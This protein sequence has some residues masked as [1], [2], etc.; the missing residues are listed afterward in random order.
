ML[1]HNELVS[2]DRSMNLPKTDDN[3][4][5]HKNDANTLSRHKANASFWT[6][7]SEEQFK[8]LGLES[9]RP[10]ASSNIVLKEENNLPPIT[11]WLFP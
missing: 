8:S 9:Q 7:V 5:T 10:Y 11:G 4:R 2:Q 3:H 1:F 6:I